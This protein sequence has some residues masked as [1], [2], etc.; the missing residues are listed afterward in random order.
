MAT[1]GKPTGVDSRELMP[2]CLINDGEDIEAFVDRM[3]KSNPLKADI[4]KNLYEYKT[5]AARLHKALNNAG[6]AVREEMQRADT[7]EQSVK[8][9]TEQVRNMQADLEARNEQMKVDIERQVEEQLKNVNLIE[10]NRMVLVNVNQTPATVSSTGTGRS[11]STT[12]NRA[13]K[14][15]NGTPT[16][17]GRPNERLDNGYILSRITWLCK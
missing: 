1:A 7:A 12:S 16:F 17:S 6:E 3:A 5:Y 15:E 4:A 8:D 14:L 2:K 11:E 10:N 13:C 9:L